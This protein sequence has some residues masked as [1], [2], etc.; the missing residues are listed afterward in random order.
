MYTVFICSQKLESNPNG[1]SISDADAYRQSRQ[2]GLN[3]TSSFQDDDLDC[4]YFEYSCMSRH[5]PMDAISD[6]NRF[7]TYYSRTRP[8]RRNILGN[9]QSHVH[10]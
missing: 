10:P 2:E 6:L 7:L 1:V 3:H 5:T 9:P 4:D 8:T